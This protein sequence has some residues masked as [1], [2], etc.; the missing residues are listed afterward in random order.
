MK[1]GPLFVLF[2]IVC[3]LSASMLFVGVE[4]EAVA[5]TPLIPASPML[6][7]DAELASCSLNAS[8]RMEAL[9]AGGD[10]C[11]GCVGCILCCFEN[12]MTCRQAG[13]DVLI[14]GNQWRECRNQCTPC[15]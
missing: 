13:G 3:L 2:T 11:S 12:Y 9:L 1:Y 4:D 5:D 6:L 10:P 7:M 14:C 15:P 8:G